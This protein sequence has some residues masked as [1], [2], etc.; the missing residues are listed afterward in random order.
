MKGPL[1]RTAEEQKIRVLEGKPFHLS[2][3]PESEY[4]LVSAD[5]DSATIRKAGATE[6][7]TIKRR[8]GAAPAASAAPAVT[9]T[10]PAASTPAPAPAGAVTPPPSP[11]GS[12]AAAPAATVA[13]PAAAPA[14][15][16]A[17]P[18][19]AGKTP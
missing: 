8:D 4:T 3:D 12:A 6:V 9:A 13:P 15:G 19:P 16:A 1:G 10:P 2:L 17:V 11:G 18:A 7:L 14:G 5:A